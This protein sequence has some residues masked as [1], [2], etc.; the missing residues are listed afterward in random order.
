MNGSLP[1]LLYLADV[2]VESSYHG[3][4]LVY[5]LL[6]EFRTERLFV[7]EHGNPS[8]AER[9]LPDVRYAVLKGQWTHPQVSRFAILAAATRDV[10]RALKFLRTSSF[11]AEAVLTVTYGTGWMT[12]YHL[13]RVLELPL[14]VIVHDDSSRGISRWPVLHQFGERTFAR[15][16]TKASSRLCV[17]PGMEEEYFRR[18]RV[19]GTVLYPSRDSKVVPWATPPDRLISPITR[20]TVAYAGTFPH[21]DYEAAL[22]MLGAVLKEFQG[23]LLVFGNVSQGMLSAVKLSGL[24]IQ[25]KTPIPS[26]ELIQQLRE[27]ADLLFV[28]VPFSESQNAVVRTSFPSKLTDYTCAGLPMLFY[29][30]SDSS[31]ILWARAEAGVAFEVTAKSALREAIRRLTQDPKLRWELALKAIEVGRRYF[32]YSVAKGTFEEALRMERLSR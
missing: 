26:T 9:R 20:L 32:D 12:A 3:S 25:I 29:A 23:E 6:S 10:S 1:R 18:Y 31:L 28:P 7:L 5:R 14:H 15:M 17:S 16:Y 21:P 30:P 2:P 19:H 24:P 4:A 8:L 13:A 22:L 27:L 11:V